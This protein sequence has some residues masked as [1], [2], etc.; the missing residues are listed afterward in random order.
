[1]K[2]VKHLTAMVFDRP[3]PD[4]DGTR[5]GVDI[6]FCNKWRALGGKIYADETQRRL[7]EWLTPANK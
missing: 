3:D 7:G 2:D 1:M 4:K 6:A 5:W